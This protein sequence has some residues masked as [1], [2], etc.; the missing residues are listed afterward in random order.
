MARPKL[1]SVLQQALSILRRPGITADVY[2]PGIG[3]LSGLATANFL[4]SV[5]TTLATVD[6]PVGLVLDAMGSVGANLVVNGGFDSAT[7]WT[8][9]AGWVISGGVATKGVGAGGLFDPKNAYTTGLTYRVTFDY[10]GPASAVTIFLRG[11]SSAIF[12]PSG[13]QQSCVLVAG[14]GAVRGV[15]FYAATGAIIDNVVAQEV[16]GIHASQPTTAAKPR[17]ERGVRN[18]LTW[19]SDFSNAAWTTPDLTEAKTQE[20]QSGTANS[21]WLITDGGGGTSLIAPLTAITVNQTSSFTVSRI[22]KY[23]NNTWVRFV[24]ATTGGDGYQVWVNML[25]GVKGTE[26]YLGAGTN[27][28][29]SVTPTSNGFYNVILSCTPNGASTALTINSYATSANTVTTRVV[30]A[31]YVI[32]SAA[33]FQ[34]TLTAAQILAEGGIP[35]TTSAAA[36]NA[37]A[38]KYSWAFDGVDDTLLLGSAP[39]TMADDHFVICSASN[40]KTTGACI[41]YG[42]AGPTTARLAQIYYNNA[43]PNISWLDDATTGNIIFTSSSQVLGSVQILS[44]RKS[45]PLFV[46]RQNG[47][48]FGSTSLINPGITTIEATRIGAH[49]L[50]ATNLHQGSIGPVIAGKG[51]LTDSEMLTL[52]RLVASLT[53]NAPSF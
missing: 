4:D 21:A 11:G 2:L 3:T 38:G 36:S 40:N 17:L 16:T 24:L 53:P 28:A 44:C 10:S 26:G 9:E 1:P 49:K 18:L 48:V 13:T 43:T 14:S 42:G 25:T 15:E 46:A 45:A 39:F 37:S 34:G 35:L 27:G 29:A 31:T 50:T 19:S 32:E 33:L 8:A 22:V 5:G 51:T 7:G 6:Q 52:E 47:V 23:G 30:G 41:I 12:T 20:N